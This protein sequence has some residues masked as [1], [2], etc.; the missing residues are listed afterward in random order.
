MTELV[1]QLRDEANAKSVESLIGVP[2]K[3]NSPHSILYIAVVDDDVADK[4][5]KTLESSPLVEIV[6]RNSRNFS[7]L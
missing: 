4:T 5:V 1:V 3:K 7:I 6:E 2:L